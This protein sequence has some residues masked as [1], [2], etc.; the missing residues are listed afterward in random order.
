MIGKIS[1]KLCDLKE[2]LLFLLRIKRKTLELL[3]LLNKYNE[4]YGK[5]GGFLI[6]NRLFDK[7]I[8]LLGSGGRPCRFDSCHPHKWESL[9][10]E[11]SRLF[12]VMATRQAFIIHRMNEHLPTAHQRDMR[13]ISR[14]QKARECLVFTGFL[15]D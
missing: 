7:S 1:W 10:D 6:I 12:F 9:D 5:I 14:G 15:A 11:S 3:V 2:N 8:E 4:F 13:S